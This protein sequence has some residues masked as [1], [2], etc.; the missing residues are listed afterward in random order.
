MKGRKQSRLDR[1]EKLIELLGE[2]VMNQDQAI[3]WLVNE[4]KQLKPE[5]NESTE[6]LSGPEGSQI[7]EEN[8][9]S[10]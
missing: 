7:Q 10:E 8:K 5:T 3:R 9:S 2:Q 6:D 4:V 1:V